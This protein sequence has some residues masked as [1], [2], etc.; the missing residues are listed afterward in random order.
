MP[1]YCFALLAHRFALDAAHI[2]YDDLPTSA[3]VPSLSSGSCRR[4]DPVV[5]WRTAL[6]RRLSTELRHVFG[7]GA[8]V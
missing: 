4:G 1:F 8:S 3:K 5:R 2:A 7:T 6:A